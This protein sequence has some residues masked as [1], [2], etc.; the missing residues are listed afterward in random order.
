MCMKN[1]KRRKSRKEKNKYI[2]REGKTKCRKKIKM[3]F[4]PL[5]PNFSFKISKCEFQEKR[6]EAKCNKSR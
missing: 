2:K 1:L 6:N 4:F 5:L 3:I